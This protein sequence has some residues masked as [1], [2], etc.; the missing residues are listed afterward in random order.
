LI[1]N[2]YFYPLRIEHENSFEAERQRVEIE[3]RKL[4]NEMREKEL[5]S[6]ETIGKLCRQLSETQ[7]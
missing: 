4:T 7:V 5:T 2:K 6:G 3:I 1:I